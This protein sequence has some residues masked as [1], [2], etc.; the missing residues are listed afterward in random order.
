MPLSFYRAIGVRTLLHKLSAEQLDHMLGVGIYAGVMAQQIDGCPLYAG[1]FTQQ[2]IEHISEAAFYHDIGKVWLP[3]TILLKHEPLTTEECVMASR[4]T[5]LAL[6]L[7]DYME[8]HVISGMPPFLILPACDAA[9][10]HH[11]RWDGG[12]YPFGL[13]GENIP[14]IARITAICDCYDKETAQKGGGHQDACYSIAQG[15]GTRFDPALA[16]VFIRYH[17]AFEAAFC[18]YRCN[19]WF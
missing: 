3:Q 7:F 13:C 2:E 19:D 1:R 18:S 5:L 16:R 15:A 4:H 12:G 6:R 8:N 17:K 10:Y 11:E 9:V 14:L